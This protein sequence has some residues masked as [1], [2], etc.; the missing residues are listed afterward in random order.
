MAALSLYRE[1][2]DLVKDRSVALEEYARSMIAAEELHA[3]DVDKMLRK[4][5]DIAAFKDRGQ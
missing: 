5:G 3:S 1:L 4:P 2:L